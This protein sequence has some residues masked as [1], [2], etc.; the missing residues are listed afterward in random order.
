MTL[1]ST[2]AQEGISYALGASKLSIGLDD[3]LVIRLY[4]VNHTD[5][6]KIRRRGF[7]VNN[8]SLGSQIL[9]R[10]HNR[11][12]FRSNTHAAKINSA[13][14]HEL[15]I[16][17]P[18]NAEVEIAEW[19]IMEM[20]F[21]TAEADEF[22]DHQMNLL[23]NIIFPGHYTIEWNDGEMIDHLPGESNKIS[24]IVS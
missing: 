23:K 14:N 22:G 17:I 10:D 15:P 6:S 7:A 8:S 11:V 2:L 5:A 16:V 24:I 18:G 4:I 19:D 21:E 12:V 13:Y 9:I 3:P 20:I 1:K